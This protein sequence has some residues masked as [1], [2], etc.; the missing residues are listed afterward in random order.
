MEESSIK[1]SAII[2]AYNEEMLIGEI[3]NQLRKQIVVE[4][5]EIILADGGS[6][7]R[8]VELAR[9]QGIKIASSKIKGKAH[10]MNE[11]AS[12]A[13]GQI[14]FF[15]HADMELCKHT[16]STIINKL[17]EGYS[18][19][20]FSNSFLSNNNKIK[21]IGNL[22]NLR[23]IDKREQSDKGIF[24]GDNGIFVLKRVF[25]ELGGFKTIPIMEDYDFSKRLSSAYRTIKIREIEIKVSARRHVK[26]GFIKTRLQ[27]I[28]IRELYK[29]GVSPY[30]LA[31]WYRDIR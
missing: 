10:Q 4:Q 15:V 23:F 31:K 14:L 13:R 5:T 19:G 8:T 12:I 26:S 22:M 1:L 21:S 27:W 30:T 25:E 7:D 28:V 18:G 9:R 11:A 6:S 16:F 24:Y 29:I 20:G 2:V 17:K 3:I